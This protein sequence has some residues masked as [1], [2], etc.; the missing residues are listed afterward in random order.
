MN[1]GFW[2]TE[3]WITIKFLDF[4]VTFAY[5]LEF[6]I[7]VGWDIANLCHFQ[8]KKHREGEYRKKIPCCIC[9]HSFSLLR[10]MLHFI[11]SLWTFP[12][13]SCEET[14]LENFGWVSWFSC[15]VL[16][17]T[18]LSIRFWLLCKKITQGSKNR[19]NPLAF[20]AS[21]LYQHNK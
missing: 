13:E 19:P 16:P 20:Q 14:Y 9:N 8:W 18:L 21:Y 1:T 10:N 17:C 7:E 12:L 15:E 5:W 2:I 11:Y 4:G 6:F 3:S